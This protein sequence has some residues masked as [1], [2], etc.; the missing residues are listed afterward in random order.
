MKISNTHTRGVLIAL[1]GTTAWAITRIFIS[2]LLNRYQ[3]APLALPFWRDLFIAVVALAGIRVLRLAALRIG[4]NDL[5]FSLLMVSWG[6]QPS[7]PCGPT[8]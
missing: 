3:L 5:P 8:V 4:R 1:T 7:T 6:W 2:V